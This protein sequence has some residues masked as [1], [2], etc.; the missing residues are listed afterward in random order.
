MFGYQLAG[1]EHI[2]L[3]SAVLGLRQV[4]TSIQVSCGFWGFHMKLWSSCLYGNCLSIEPSP[5]IYLLPNKT[6]I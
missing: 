5:T 3:L 6:E 1:V 4:N 2:Y